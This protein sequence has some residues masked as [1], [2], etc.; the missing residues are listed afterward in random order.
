MSVL[1]R[2]LLRL[3]Y[4]LPEQSPTA[5][6]YGVLGRSFRDRSMAALFGPTVYTRHPGWIDALG[7]GAVFISPRELLAAGD[8]YETRRVFERELV[9]LNGQGGVVDGRADAV[10]AVG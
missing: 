6:W 5:A 7:V 2:A 8:E 4:R 9:V 3:T 1:R 10:A